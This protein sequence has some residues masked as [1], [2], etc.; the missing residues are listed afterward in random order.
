[1]VPPRL[2]LSRR[3]RG[4]RCLF[5][6]ATGGG[7]GGALRRMGEEQEGEAAVTRRSETAGAAFCMKGMGQ[8]T[9]RVTAVHCDQRDARVS[10]LGCRESQSDSV[11]GGWPW[12][13]FCH[14]SWLVAVDSF[15]RLLS[16]KYALR[17]V[18]RHLCQLPSPWLPGVSR[19]SPSSNVDSI[20]PN[21]LV[22]N[23]LRTRPPTN[24]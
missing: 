19:C 21:K 2:G 15:F 8:M 14:I 3:G 13:R 24:Q 23:I 5:M 12:W 20:S 16:I 17:P 22:S 7:A 9:S 1:M 18:S 4:R 11:G 10:P 6:W